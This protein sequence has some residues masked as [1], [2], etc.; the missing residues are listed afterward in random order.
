[1]FSTF[2]SGQSAAHILQW[3]AV[4]SDSTPPSIPTRRVVSRDEHMPT[5]LLC[6]LLPGRAPDIHRRFHSIRTIRQNLVTTCLQAH[7]KVG[8]T[9]HAAARQSVPAMLGLFPTCSDDPPDSF[10][11]L[12]C[13]LKGADAARVVYLDL[14]RIFLRLRFKRLM[15]FFLHCT[16]KPPLTSRG[17]MS[18]NK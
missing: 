9:L 4:N 3:Y 6:R 2:H 5:G 17:C 16:H 10:L 18:I 14:W 8:M 7:A 13:K 15:R 1:M 11:R 12:H